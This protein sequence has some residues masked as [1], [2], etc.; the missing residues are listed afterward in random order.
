MLY[1]I[2][3]LSAITVINLSKWDN[4]LYLV[5]AIKLFSTTDADHLRNN[6]DKVAEYVIVIAQMFPKSFRLKEFGLMGK[7][8]FVQGL[9]IGDG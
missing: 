8:G 9:R 5:E 6:L 3:R 7:S 1:L 4:V 2:N